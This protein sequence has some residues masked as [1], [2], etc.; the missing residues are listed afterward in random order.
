MDAPHHLRAD[1][2]CSF[3]EGVVTEEKHKSGVSYANVG[4]FSD[5]QIDKALEPGTRVTLKLVTKKNRL[6]GEC[7]NA[8]VPRE[9][10][11]LYWGYKVRIAQS[12]AE[13]FTETPFKGILACCCPVFLGPFLATLFHFVNMM[14]SLEGYDLTIGTS[15]NGDTLL[16]DAS[17]ALPDFNVSIRM[18]CVHVKL[19][20]C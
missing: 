17:F 3:R 6:V 20:L 18:S 14:M 15:E 1:E 16:E 19:F 13:I 5:V 4:L 2:Q 8:E 10:T 11:G 9:T 7:V 12:I